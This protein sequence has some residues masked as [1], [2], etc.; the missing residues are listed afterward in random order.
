M[1]KIKIDVLSDDNWVTIEATTT[2]K[3]NNNRD[4]IW[5]NNDKTRVKQIGLFL[6]ILQVGKTKIKINTAKSKKFLEKNEVQ[7]PLGNTSGNSILQIVENDEHILHIKSNTKR[8]C[9]NCKLTFTSKTEF[10]DHKST[11]HHCIN[12]KRS[13]L[14]S[15]HIKPLKN[16]FM[17]RKVTLTNAETHNIR[18]V[19]A[20]KIILED[21]IYHNITESVIIQHQYTETNHSNTNKITINKE[22]QP[23]EDI[24]LNI[25]ITGSGH[26]YTSGK[27]R[28]LLTFFR[29][30][31]CYDMIE[32]EARGHTI[33]NEIFIENL[34]TTSETWKTNTIIP[35]TPNELNPTNWYSRYQIPPKEKKAISILESGSTSRDPEIQQISSNIIK[36]LKTDV[37][38]DTYEEKIML[39]LQLEEAAKSKNY[40]LQKVKLTTNP[41]QE[42]ELQIPEFQTNFLDCREGETIIIRDS[43]RRT[44]NF[45]ATILSITN[46][47]TRITLHSPGPYP[48]LADIKK[49][50]TAFSMH[51][52]HTCLIGQGMEKTKTLIFPEEHQ[53]C[54]KTSKIYQT[55]NPEQRK[56][57]NAILGMDEKAPFL[58]SGCPGSGKTTVILET[59]LNVIDTH[60][61][62][63]STPTNSAADSI[64]KKVNLLFK[65][66]NINKSI[67]RLATPNHEVTEECENC[68]IDNGKHYYPKCEELNEIQLI[69]TTTITAARLGNTKK[70]PW[71]PDIIFVDEAAFPAEDQIIPTITPF[72]TNKTPKIIFIGDEK[73]I[74][75]TPRS[76]ISNAAKFPSNIMDR[77]GNAEAYKNPNS[78][79]FTLNTNHRNPASIVRLLNQISYNNT[80]IPTKPETKHNI[81]AIH[82][83]SIVEELGNSKFA[84]GEALSVVDICKKIIESDPTSTPVVLT[85]YS[86]QR[87]IIR[88][89]L[90]SNNIS[91]TVQTAENI[92]GEESEHVILST[93]ATFD[94]SFNCTSTWAKNERRAVVALSRSK[95]TLY[96]VGNL[97][98]ISTIEN[99]K[100]VVREALQNEDL[101][102][103]S[104][105]VRSILESRLSGK[106]H[107]GL[108][109]HSP[110]HQGI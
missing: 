48:D 39:H 83:E 89:L 40:T 24:D 1:K 46:N 4:I 109:G 12:L 42:A 9:K 91:A 17:S 78:N 2:K 80:I 94:Q 37:T 100:E 101:Y 19:S 8:S 31:Q 99:L 14:C 34:N 23:N 92:Q 43:D 88:F 108:I 32:I 63:I 73:Q 69:V 105:K 7:L 86:A 20:E 52:V 71:N 30:V 76:V 18:L 66:F 87:T 58:L 98:C 97:I 96:I 67:R 93:C 107:N 22:I 82:V 15:N 62:L 26:T 104:L 79:R 61:V 95:N 25:K 102:N 41:G 6:T 50:Q 16:I 47:V 49:L 57:V 68:F 33:P 53:N 56:A 5:K 10:K 44:S 65:R 106:Q 85:Y 13:I 77:I 64:T 75:Y 54:P 35:S 3:I 70:G 51:I 103:A 29:G 11:E 84:Y 38:Q 60:K 59:V 36:T 28:L 45:L 21:I 27:I 74:T 110:F 81:R 72:L 90:K 55:T